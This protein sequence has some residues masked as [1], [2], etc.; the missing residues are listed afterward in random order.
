MTGIVAAALLSATGANA[1]DFF[2]TSHP[3]EFL[4]CD[5][6]VNLGASWVTQNYA[7]MIAINDM[8]LVPG[9][10]FG[11]GFRGVL[12]IRNYLAIGAEANFNVNN[13]HYTA[14]GVSITNPVV[15]GLASDNR[16]CYLNFPIF[17][18]LRFNVSERVRWNI[19][20]GMYYSYGTGGYSNL[21]M[22]SSYE[23]DLGQFITDEH[24]IDNSYFSRERPLLHD[25][26]HSDLG[27]HFATGCRFYEHYSVSFVFQYGLKDVSERD[28]DQASVHNIRAGVSLGYSF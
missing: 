25:V 17:A 19:D 11:F 21:T 7:E 27:L 13:Y 2:D 8:S 20:G 4:E 26:H 22:Y 6:H 14:I 5:A 1:S 10:S 23:N 28:N 3:K 24:K 12:A 9:G 15:A 16:Y 18:S